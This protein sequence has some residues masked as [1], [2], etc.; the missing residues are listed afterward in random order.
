MPPPIKEQL[1]AQ[2]NRFSQPSGS[3][4]SPSPPPPST[5]H[6]SGGS[7]GGGELPPNTSG[8]NGSPPSPTSHDDIPPSHITRRQPSIKDMHAVNVPAA[9]KRLRDLELVMTTLLRDYHVA[10]RRIRQL[11]ETKGNNSSSTS[12][13]GSHKHK[14]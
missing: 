9:E 14:D 5:N 6:S 7:G 1:E 13:S 11:E 10:K 2:A 12:T 3:S 8:L 4:P